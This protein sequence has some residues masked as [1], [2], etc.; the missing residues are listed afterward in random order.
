MNITNGSHLVVG[1]RA[2]SA[3]DEFL[4]NPYQKYEWLVYRLRREFGQDNIAFQTQDFGFTLMAGITQLGP[5]LK[6]RRCVL[7]V[8]RLICLH[9]FKLPGEE[10]YGSEC[11]DAGDQGHRVY[12]IEQKA[13]EVGRHK[14]LDQT[15]DGI[16]EELA[17]SIEKEH[18]NAKE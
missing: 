8:R 13:E 15:V 10:G 6:K 17:K 14:F 5:D 1:A 18:K 11:E 9:P 2:F 4:S 3:K 7:L 16:R 12:D